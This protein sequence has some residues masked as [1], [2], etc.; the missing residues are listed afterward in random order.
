[1]FRRQSKAGTSKHQKNKK[2]VPKGLFTVIHWR[3]L[4]PDC[5]C[6]TKSLPCLVCFLSW[7]FCVSLLLGREVVCVCGGKEGEEE[8]RGDVGNPCP[9]PIWD[10]NM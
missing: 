9:G 1:M 5:P 3:V 7:S 4:P 10:Q 2:D 6:W 8:K